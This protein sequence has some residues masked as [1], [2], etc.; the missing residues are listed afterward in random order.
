MSLEVEIDRA[1]NED[2]TKGAERQAEEEEEK[3]HNSRTILRIHALTATGPKE[4]AFRVGDNPV[5]TAER[6]CAEEGPKCRPVIDAIAYYI[7]K[8]SRP[9]PPAVYQSYDSA[10]A[11]YGYPT[12]PSTQP[13][14][15]YRPFP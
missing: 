2:Q 11:Q 7:E 12:F 8:S 15:Y 9:Y 3:V 6:I 5:R 4:F 1:S 10:L 13:R 14:P